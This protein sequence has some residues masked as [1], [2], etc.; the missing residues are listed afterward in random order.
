MCNILAVCSMNIKMQY[1]L[2]RSASEGNLAN[3][4]IHPSLA[5]RASVVIAANG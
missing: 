5:L 2:A 1:T 3:I 4:D